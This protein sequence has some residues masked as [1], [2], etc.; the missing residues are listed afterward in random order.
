M[1][2]GGSGFGADEPDPF[3]PEMPPME[4]ILPDVRTIQ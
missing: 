4:R 2:E 1:N 3:D